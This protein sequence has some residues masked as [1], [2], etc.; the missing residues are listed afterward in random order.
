MSANHPQAEEPGCF[1]LF[2]LGIA[3]DGGVPHLG[4]SKPC[5]LEA[6]QS[7]RQLLPASLG[8]HDRESGRLL[9]IE[10]TPAIEAQVARLHELSGAE[11]PSR[12]PFDALLI[13]HAHIGHYLGLAQLGREVAATQELP[14]HVTP[15]MAEFFAR[16]APWEQVLRLGQVQLREQRPGARFEVLPGLELETIEVP[17]RNE[18]ADTVALRIHGPRRCVLF[19]PDIDSWD[20]EEGILS[21]LLEGVDVAYLDG[22]WYDGSE[23]P[24][25]DLRE[26]P[27]PPIVQTVERLAAEA[28]AQPGRIRFLHLN[29]TNPLL[30]DPAAVAALEARGFL[31]AEEG[32]RV[33][34]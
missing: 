5:C 6:R 26:V 2:V 4:C 33:E 14:L 20:A 16:N 9:L 3:Q 29:H 17:H 21:R 12:E 15:A 13:T 25:R 22:T 27:H 31:L 10:A 34:L 28:A 19:C 1:E 24:G 32:E 8:V 18:F 11:R 7:G 23:L 30:R